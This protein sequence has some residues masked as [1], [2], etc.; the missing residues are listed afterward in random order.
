MLRVRPVGAF[1]DNYIWLIETP[2]RPDSVV[3]VDPGDAAP[4]LA[5]LA[6]SKLKLA[7]ILLTH[8]HPDHVGGVGELLRHGPVPVIG[9]AD[10]RIAFLTRSVGDGENFEIP[11]LR[12]A[13]QT[14][15]VPGHTLTHVAFFGHGAVF[16]GDTLF[17]AGCG[18][19]FEGTPEQMNR[20]L[21]RLRDLPATTLVY[22]GHEYTQANLRFARAVEPDNAA[23]QTHQR[24]VETRRG[25]DQPTLPSELSL[26][27]RVN[28]FLRCDDPGVRASAERH[29]GHAL[30][31]ESDVFAVLR[32]WKDKFQ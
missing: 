8:H 25:A 21:N 14:L 1:A 29:A 18:R 20:S 13:F 6:R 27:V 15:H 24:T 16:C 3:V 31:R 17:S 4:V 12:L 11:E 23:I 7:A 19:M 10:P 9:P 5:E 32:A 28:P 30:T 2:H 22:C 26:E